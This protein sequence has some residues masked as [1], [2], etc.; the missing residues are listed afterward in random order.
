[1]KR[2]DGSYLTFT[3]GKKQYSRLNRCSPV[4]RLSRDPHLPVLDIRTGLCYSQISQGS[5]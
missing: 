3:E 1:M 4:P 2:S 5:N